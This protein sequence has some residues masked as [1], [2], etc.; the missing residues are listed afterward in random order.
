LSSSSSLSLNLLFAA[1]CFLGAGTGYFCTT[2]AAADAF[3]GYGAGSSSESAS[4]VGRGFLTSTGG[5]IAALG[6][7]T[8]A[9]GFTSSSSESSNICLV[10]FA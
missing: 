8:V 10:V 5:A 6:W 9:L 3:L 4:K 1:V 7:P 2:V